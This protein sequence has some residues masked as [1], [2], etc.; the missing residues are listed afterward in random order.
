[1]IIPSG[2]REKGGQKTALAMQICLVK[3]KLQLCIR[4]FKYNSQ[5]AVLTCDR[6]FDLVLN[7]AD[8]RFLVHKKKKQTKKNNQ[9]NLHTKYN[10]RAGI[11]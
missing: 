4:L 3:W 1:M 10:K 9:T 6:E 5:S 11:K 8:S 7:N 2:L